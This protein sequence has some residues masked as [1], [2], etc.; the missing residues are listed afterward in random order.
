MQ[1]TTM[2]AVILAGGQ[3]SR[4][5]TPKELLRWRGGTILSELIKEVRALGLE[6]LVV[7]NTP[8]RLK[9]EDIES[10]EV[11]V[12]PDLVPSAGPVSGIVTAFRAT[13]EDVLLLLSCDLPFMDR[14]Q[15]EKL[16]QFAKGW[17]DW[18]VVAVKQNGR[19][20][21]LCALYHRRTQP[22]WEQALLEGQYRVMHTLDRLRVHTTPEDLLEEWAAFNANTPEEY[23]AALALEKKRKR[24]DG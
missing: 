11:Q 23:Q 8:E 22:L 6:C 16:I 15:M 10:S 2:K 5:G 18:D 9:R 21:P 3:S 4:M 14:G 13:E 17:K 1:E 20:H 7:S 19:L 24:E 12:T